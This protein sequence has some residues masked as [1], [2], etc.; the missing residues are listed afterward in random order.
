MSWC[1]RVSITPT[2]N[3]I[4]LLPGMR[5]SWY[6]QPV[7]FSRLPVAGGRLSCAL[8]WHGARPALL[9][10]FDGDMPDGYRLTCAALDPEFES[11]ESSGEVLLNVPLDAQS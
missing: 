6:G 1:R 11:T 4:D 2:G 10:E 8:R 5:R 9:W 3:V 7:S